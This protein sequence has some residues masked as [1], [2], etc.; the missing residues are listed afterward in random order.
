[1]ARPTASQQVYSILLPLQVITTRRT[2]MASYLA[3]CK[4]I[5]VPWISLETI[6]FSLICNH[7]IL[8]STALIT[9]S[10]SS[11][12]NTNSSK[13][14]IITP[15]K[16]GYKWSHSK[17][18]APLQVWQVDVYKGKHS[19]WDNTKI[20]YKVMKVLMRRDDVDTIVKIC[21][22]F[23]NININNNNK[24]STKCN[25]HKKKVGIILV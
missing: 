7:R 14:I 13:T 5:L 3:N 22:R 12:I 17:W 1:V 9:I 10:N 24:N 18:L 6:Q 20:I 16:L 15:S 4:R 2:T 8:Q 21:M 11:N 19:I 25:N 23:N